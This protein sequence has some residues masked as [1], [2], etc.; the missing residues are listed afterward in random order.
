MRSGDA[1]TVTGSERFAIKIGNAGGTR[2][3]FND[4]DLG[5]LGPHG[6]VV[7]IVLP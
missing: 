2:L 3:I 7:D 5:E 6:K 1:V 4:E